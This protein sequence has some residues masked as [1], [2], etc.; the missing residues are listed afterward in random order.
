MKFTLTNVHRLEF[1]LTLD[2]ITYS[3]SRFPRLLIFLRGFYEIRF[4]VGSHTVKMTV[5]EENQYNR[6]GI[7]VVFDDILVSRRSG[8]AT[9]WVDTAY[10]PNAK[11][12][13]IVEKAIGDL[14]AEELRADPT[15]RHA[16]AAEYAAYLADRKAESLARTARLDEVLTRP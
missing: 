1:P 13:E 10:L 8:F 6:P 11:L 4:R 5:R 16:H 3:R 12:I 2:N 9:W 15:G 14:E 7:A